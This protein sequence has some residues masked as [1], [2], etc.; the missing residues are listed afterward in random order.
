MHSA[1][2]YIDELAARGRHHFTTQD[3]RVALGGSLP[4]VRASLR[5]LQHRGAISDPHRGFYV[6]VPPEYRRLGCL[7]P[8]QFIHE[9]MSQLGETYYVALLSAAELH[10]AAHHRPQTFQVMLGKQ[11]RQIVCGEVRVQFLLRRDLDKTAV[12]EMNTPR[13]RLRVASPDATA[14]ELVGYA[15]QCGG[16]D[17]V[18]SVLSELAE[19]LSAEKLVEAARL[20]PVAWVQRLGYLFEL[21][22]QDDLANALEAQVRERAVAFAPLIRAQSTAHAKR[23]QRWK[24]AVNAT[25]E[26]ER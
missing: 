5:R 23:L 19:A 4:A 26:P 3:A 25:V 15:D 21:L 12:V 9:L 11:R 24:L 14:L 6:I 20:C 18:A 1:S 17:N 10:G 2:A 7:P 16:L 22:D 8:E 13:G